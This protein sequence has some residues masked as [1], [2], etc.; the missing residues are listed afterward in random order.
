MIMHIILLMLIMEI[1]SKKMLNLSRL[2]LARQQLGTMIRLFF[3][4]Y[5]FTQLLQ[6]NVLWTLCILC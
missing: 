5:Q 1:I 6:I 2:F 3:Q 4:L